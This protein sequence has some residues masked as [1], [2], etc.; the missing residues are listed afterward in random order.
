MVE[1]VTRTRLF[2]GPLWENWKKQT[3]G[4]VGGLQQETFID[5]LT[6]RDIFQSDP[7]RL[8]E[9][10]QD[11]YASELLAGAYDGGEFSPVEQQRI[12]A[13]QYLDEEKTG[14]GAPFRADRLQQNRNYLSLYQ[15]TE[16]PDLE[17]LPRN[18]QESSED[19]RFPITGLGTMAGVGA[20]PPRP[21]RK[22]VTEYG[23]ATEDIFIDEDERELLNR[24]EVNPNRYFEA[25]EGFLNKWIND[26]P[27]DI[28]SFLTRGPGELLSPLSAPLR[29]IDITAE[30]PWRLKAFFLPANPTPEEMESIMLNEF[31]DIQGRIRYINPRDPDSGLAIR[32]PKK[33]AFGSVGEDG[34]VQLAQEEYIPLRPQFGMS[35]LSEEGLTL[36]GYE[37]GT[38]L[39]E[40]ALTQG[41]GSMARLIK[42][43]TEDLVKL[44]RKG[45]MGRAFTNAGV[46]SLAAAFGRYAQMV[47][48]REKGIINLSETRMF[49]DA[50]IAAALAGV[51]SL[52]ASAALGVLSKIHR[53]AT[54]NDIPDS[55]LASLQR[56]IEVL[57]GS[58]KRAEFTNQELIDIAGEAG[59][60]VGDTINFRPT[61]G[62]MTEDAELQTMEQELFSFLA[63]KGSK[64]AAAFEDIIINNREAAFKFWQAV[65]KGNPELQ[66][67]KLTEFQDY[68]KARNK[69][70]V[71]EAKLAAEIE[72][73]KIIESARLGIPEQSPISQTTEDLAQPFIRDTETGGLVFKRNSKEFLLGADAEFQSLKSEYESAINTLSNVRYPRKGQSTALMVDEFRKVLNAG[74]AD[75]IIKLMADVELAGV[76]KDLVPMRNG[77]STLRQLAGEIRDSKGKFLP[78]LDLSYGDLVSMRNA[79]ENILLTHPDNAVKSAA[80]P[81][82]EAIDAQ[83]DDLLK[84]RAREDFAER[85]IDSPSD[86]RLEKY[87]K[88][89]AE[90][91]APLFAARDAF[92][93]FKVNFDRKFLKEFSQKQPEELAPF[94][95]KSAPE[96]I[97]KLL[98]NIYGSSDSIVKLQN[99]RQLVLDD[100]RK[101]VGEGSL[102][103]QNKLWK[104]YFDQNEEQLKALFPDAEFLK[105]KKYSNVQEQGLADIQAVEEAVVDL[106]KQLGIEES[107]TNFIENILTPGSKR[108]LEGRDLEA[109][110]KFR[111]VLDR[112]P[113]LQGLVGEMTKGHMKKL[114][115][116]YKLYAP[117]LRGPEGQMFIGDGF[118][119]EGFK[120]LIDDGLGSGP[121]AGENLA[122]R[123]SLIYGPEVGRKYVQN[124]RALGMLFDKQQK[125]PVD[126]VLDRGARAT[127]DTLD[128]F[129]GL[130]S[131]FQRTFVSPLSVLSRRITFGKEKLRVNAADDLLQII[132]DPTKLD[133]LIRNRDRRMTGKEFVEFLS[134][135][136]LS[137]SYVDIGSGEGETA[138]ERLIRDLEEEDPLG[139]P[140][141]TKSGVDTMSRIIDLLNPYDIFDESSP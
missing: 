139:I 24:F 30:S 131:A 115:E 14:T 111:T 45:G 70:L 2:S 101:S 12:D 56:K 116:S 46:T 58:E 95:L 6:I 44:P 32:V 138:T 78:K 129:V 31:P 99:I 35:M 8:N 94:I 41:R 106:E 96:Q 21:V 126:E 113:E 53:L 54:G 7:R 1:T 27:S 82:L 29:Q 109:L 83:A 112:F 103:E 108:R 18:V 49:E 67:V 90:W 130:I 61:L 38:L 4:D 28:V 91:A 37:T 26:Q 63:G 118:N 65:T 77:V 10:L 47:T 84:V 93:A 86:L 62:Q 102:E 137:R 33:G 25:G 110:E 59:A 5:G 60:A 85:G 72:Q 22:P 20:S 133:K 79:V 13:Q 125:A 36:L 122:E 121:E 89:E 134:G 57:K 17:P 124:L 92:D 100:I 119:F 141:T 98:Q 9:Y 97:E 51:G 71:E 66:K 73:E 75:D 114:L 104:K 132:I 39:A 127:K 15:K 135:L 68:I 42:E 19:R 23:V 74:G 43:G 140:S 64:A 40:A 55:M 81:L 80:K 69:E 76:L 34:R 117:T 120:N 52:G 107:F 105:L 48:A 88:E 11:R 123:F 50:K 87:I 16:R 3:L 128:G 136:A